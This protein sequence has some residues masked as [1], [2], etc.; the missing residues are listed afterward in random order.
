MKIHGGKGS[1][2]DLYTKSKVSKK[3]E[4]VSESSSGTVAK[5]S[6]EISTQQGAEV[7][8]AKEVISEQP[9]VRTE[10][11]REVKKEVDAGTY[12]VDEGKVAD[13]ILKE[14]I[15]DELL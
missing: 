8:K 11:V 3:K 14:N 6:V 1:N 4:A 5:D 2:A 7:R 10:V 13:K 9:E 12:R 15:L